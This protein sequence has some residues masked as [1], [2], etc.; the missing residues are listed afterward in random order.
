MSSG[1]PRQ[2][3]ILAREPCSVLVGGRSLCGSALTFDDSPVSWI[4][5]E[6]FHDRMV[7]LA[8]KGECE[9]VAFLIVILFLL[10]IVP[11]H[12]SHQG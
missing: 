4:M 11:S 8:E 9:P 7:E 2:T 10:L 3:T 5:G 6:E 1:S 12:P